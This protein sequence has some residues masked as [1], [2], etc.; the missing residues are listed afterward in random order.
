MP[1]HLKYKDLIRRFK[2]HAEDDVLMVASE[3]EAAFYSQDGMIRIIGIAEDED[4]DGN[5][6][7]KE[8]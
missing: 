7:V 3:G 2:K 8:D 4:K 5:M 1:K 6:Y